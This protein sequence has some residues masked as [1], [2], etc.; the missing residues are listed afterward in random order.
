MSH[1]NFNEKFQNILYTTNNDNIVAI[2]MRVGSL[3]WK[4]LCLEKDT[5][6]AR[7]LQASLE[8]LTD[9]RTSSVHTHIC[10]DHNPTSRSI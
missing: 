9:L 3:G 10:N 1:Y 2:F 7:Q 8:Q 4:I 5:K 6:I